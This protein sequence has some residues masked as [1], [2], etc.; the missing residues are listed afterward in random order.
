MNNIT[1]SHSSLLIK[2]L[3][4]TLLLSVTLILPKSAN[5]ASKEYEVYKKIKTEMTVVEVAK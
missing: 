5:A 1:N 4:L 3:I 2:V